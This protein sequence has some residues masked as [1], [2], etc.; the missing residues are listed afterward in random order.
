M[1]CPE[2]PALSRLIEESKAA[3]AAMTPAEREAMWQAQRESWL[4]GELAMGSDADEARWVR[5]NMDSRDD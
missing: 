4:R 1:K 2:R 3:V 5:E